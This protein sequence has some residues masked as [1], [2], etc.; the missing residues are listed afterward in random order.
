M[1]TNR[2]VNS[3][4]LVIDDEEQNI[5]FLETLLVEAGFTNVFS[6]QDSREAVT[7][8]KNL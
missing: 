5:L 2:N 3:K 7:W 4:I 6:I 8:F 1:R